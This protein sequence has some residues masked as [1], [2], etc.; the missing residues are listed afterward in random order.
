[1]GTLFTLGVGLDLLTPLALPTA[2]SVA[3]APAKP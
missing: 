3:P 2:S 1:V